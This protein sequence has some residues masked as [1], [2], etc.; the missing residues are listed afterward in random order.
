MSQFKKRYLLL[1]CIVALVFAGCS[2]RDQLPKEVYEQDGRII[3]GQYIVV[4]NSTTPLNNR[5]RDISGYYARK[6]AVKDFATEMLRSDR[7]KPEVIS[8][9]Y[10]TA[11]SGFVASLSDA[12]VT[13]LKQDQ[14]V[15][16]IEPDRIIQLPPMEMEA[17]GGHHGKPGGSQPQQTTPWG[18]ARIGGP[19]DGTGKTIWIID[20]G[21]DF[22]HPDLNVDIADSKTFVPRTRD[23]NDQNGHGT[24]V[25]GIAAAKNN[26]IGVVGVAAGATLVSLRV[27]DRRGSGQFS[28]SISAFDWL[29][30]NGHAGD[31][32]NYSVGPQS[33]YTDPVLDDAAL[34]V[35]RAGIHLCVAAGNSSD[36][37][38]YYSPADASGANFEVVSA[39]GQGDSWAYFSNYGSTVSHCAPGINIYSTYKNSSYA[40]LSGTSMATPH[41]TGLA[42]LGT[43]HNDG[44]VSGDPD[45][46]PDPIAHR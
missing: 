18:I 11:L 3:P 40:T 21:I 1:T 7:I 23:A 36:D 14:R 15:K 13:V 6:S 33:R 42:A 8:E 24:H 46:D 44:Y 32:A 43:I 27:L 30:A 4:L 41:V 38:K 5:L 10:G 31:A 29:A 25:S 35:A 20:T 39:M 28:W 26:N 2:Q 16:Y 12:Q 9:T 19:A 37:V 22:T 34:G 17:R 45:N